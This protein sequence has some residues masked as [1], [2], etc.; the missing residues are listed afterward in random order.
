M[1]VV[2]QIIVA[3]VSVLFIFSLTNALTLYRA[4]SAKDSL[5][6]VIQHSQTL[7]EVSRQLQ[8]R[9]QALDLE[10]AGLLSLHDFLAYN[11]TVLSLNNT[12]QLLKKEAEQAMH[13]SIIEPKQWQ[14]LLASIFT[15]L[16]QL[17]EHKKILLQREQK[18]LADRQEM[19]NL[20][21]S[22]DI[23][24]K[25]VLSNVGADEFLQKDIEAYLEKRNAAIAMAN[26]ILFLNN[27]KETE[28][29]QQQ[30]RLLQMNLEEEEEY[31][32]DEI[33]ALSKELDYQSANS[34]LNQF[35]FSEHSLASQKVAVLTHYEQLN[36]LQIRYQDSAQQFA[37]EITQ[38]ASYVLANNQTVKEDVTSVLDTIVTVQWMTLA[39]SVG[40]LLVAGAVL[41]HQIQ[42]PIGYLLNILQQL[43]DGNYAQKVKT[44]G[45]SREFT[46][47]AEMLDNVMNVNRNLIRQVKMN[48]HDLK[49]QSEQNSLAIHQVCT[50]GQEQTLAMHSISA[51]TEELEN[52][53]DETQQAIEKSTVHTQDINGIVAQT[54]NTVSHNVFGNEQL[55]L[56][57]EQSS[58]TI[59]NVAKRTEDISQ[60]IGVIDNIAYQTNL[61]ALNAAIEAA[62]AGEHG[63]GFAVVSDE[64][65]N[66]AKQ[67]TLSTHKIQTLIENLHQASAQA[68]QSMS[69]CSEQMDRNTQYLAETKAAI[70]QI[71]SHISSLVE[72]TDI[73]TRSASE[74]HHSCAHI[75]SSVAMVVSGL[76]SNIHALQQVNQRSHHLMELSQVQH[77]EL[78]K[79]LT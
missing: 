58:Q 70:A 24:L 50:S 20:V 48:N 61:L 25:R 43:V 12:F 21:V 67:T 17:Q 26:R 45:W 57:I 66:L 3:F 36:D 76:E 64:V 10:L 75:A 19:D 4:A 60:I 31:L 79:F 59:S 15:T 22:A 30:L 72:E 68:V 44:T 56:L 62:R 42:R 38:V 73:V 77:Q 29:I 23:T 47:L 8:H 51:A 53:S 37:K 32:Y 14:R 16:V 71:D 63:R 13:L 7:N 54:L 49:L 55:E 5:A 78:D 18:I 28:I 2:T 35:L 1:K 52:I 33:P 46:L 27:L 34:K 69:L 11:D 6:L 74:Q 41:A 9:N 39:G 40:V 65:S